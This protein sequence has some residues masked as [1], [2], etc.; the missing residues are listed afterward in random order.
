MAAKTDGKPAV[1][2][3]VAKPIQGTYGEV[4]L[5]Q[6]VPANAAPYAAEAGWY[7]IRDPFDVEA[8]DAW[9]RSHEAPFNAPR[10]QP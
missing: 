7:V 9:E 1:R 10:I 3:W 2:V 4:E 8:L 6:P 5:M